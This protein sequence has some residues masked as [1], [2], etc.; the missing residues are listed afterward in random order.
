MGTWTNNDGLFIKL[1]ADE[2]RVGTTVGWA[3]EYMDAT[4][5]SHVVEVILTPMTALATGSTIVSDT[6]TIPSGAKIESVWLFT[7]VAATSGG[8]A[9]LNVGLIDQ[10]RTTA[11][12]SNGF[13]EAIALTSIDAVGETTVYTLGTTGAGTLVGATLSNTGLIV[14]DYDTA[15][16]TAGRVRIRIKYHV[17][18]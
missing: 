13:L 12:D 15:A 16:Y 10:D 7:D 6:V 18:I 3:G 2:A 8:A 9:A 1:G 17:P 4:D 5:G 11:F 14:A